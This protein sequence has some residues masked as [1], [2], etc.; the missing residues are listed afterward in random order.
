MTQHGHP[1][2]LQQQANPN[3][4][5]ELLIDGARY[6]D[7]EDIQMALDNRADIDSADSMGR[8]GWG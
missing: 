8:T 1:S 7:M 4:H 2:D 6:G 3:E 5:A